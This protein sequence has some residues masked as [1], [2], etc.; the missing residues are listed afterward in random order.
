MFKLLIFF[1][2]ALIV[3][4][5]VLF[6]SVPLISTDLNQS[7]LKA[8]DQNIEIVYICTGTFAFSIV[9]LVYLFYVERKQVN[10]GSGDF[11]GVRPLTRYIQ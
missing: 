3:S 11:H 5:I 2:I 10:T 6:V 9:G 1:I 8:L 7:L 4:I